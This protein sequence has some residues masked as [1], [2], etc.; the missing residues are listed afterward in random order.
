MAVLT[1]NQSNRPIGGTGNVPALDGLRGLACLLV[2]FSHAGNQGLFYP[3]KGTGQIGVMLFFS[4]SGFLMSYLY[5][6]SRLGAVGWTSYALKRFFR[7]Y[8]AYLLVVV[9]SH[10]LYSSV[11]KY[12]FRINDA[13]LINHILL[14]G[15]VSILWT[16]PVEMKFYVVFPFLALAISALKSKGAKSF[17]AVG[18]LMGFFYLDLKG[19]KLSILPYLEFFTGGVAAG[20]I[21]AW[22]LKLKVDLKWVFNV[23]FGVSL[24]GLFMSIPVLFKELFG[25]SHRYWGDGPALSSLMALC[26]LSC[27]LSSG[28]LNRLFSN[29]IARFLGNISF[30]LYLI[31]LPCIRFVKAQLSLAAPFELFGA[32]VTSVVA[33]YLL[34]LAVER[35]SRN[36]GRYLS[37]AIQARWLNAPAS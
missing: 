21:Y 7:V 13:E 28:L 19:N 16:I 1:A 22:L 4:L 29:S 3:I 26:V 25:F 35:P 12:G 31:H 5:G 14:N 27:A 2:V 32:L 18:I 11:G 36:V 8:P 17:A 6:G 15:K 9:L 20:Y 37:D 10:I 33:A 30:S 34:H 24:C 23:I